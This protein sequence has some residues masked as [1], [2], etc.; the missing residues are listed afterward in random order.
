M[1]SSLYNILG[2]SE[3]ATLADIKCAYRKLS[4]RHHPDRGGDEEKFKEISGAY[5]ILSDND[6][7]QEYDNPQDISDIFRGFGGNGQSNNMNE[8][9]NLFSMMFNGGV[10]GGD[11]RD[12]MQF[13]GSNVF[14]G[15]GGGGGPDIRI[16]HNGV[17]LDSTG[18]G[19]GGM[20]MGGHPFFKNIQKPPCIIK[21]IKIT[22]TQAYSGISF[23]LEIERWISEGSSK[24]TEKET[25]YI[26]IPNGI[27]ENEIIILREKGHVLNEENIGDIKINIQIDNNTEFKR[28]GLD[29]IY[30][31][32][33]SL[34]ESLCGF[35]FELTHLNGKTLCLNNK[36]NMTIIKPNY[37]KVIPAM[38][39]TRDE[40]IGNLIIEFDI[41]YPDTLTSEQIE[42]LGE[43]LN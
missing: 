2:L 7:R 38:G 36:T 33:I 19:F 35:S 39:M 40:R 20:D 12:G 28:C 4:L 16:F 1:P 32:T 34:K 24:T 3:R 8:I 22:M 31:R 37:T 9:N 30:K 5:E 17:S 23:P 6:K 26:D 25:I 42:K 15:M 10:N 27:D 14:H 18:N 21:N 11:N 13:R 29:I 43:I 41:V